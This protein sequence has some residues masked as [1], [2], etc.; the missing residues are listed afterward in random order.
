MASDRIINGSQGNYITCHVSRRLIGVL[1]L[2]I[3]LDV[4]TFCSQ[5][6]LSGVSVD[7]LIMSELIS[8][9]ALAFTTGTGEISGGGGGAAS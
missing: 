6:G 8:D 2:Y 3:F 4:R 9:V 1:P 7:L 5:P